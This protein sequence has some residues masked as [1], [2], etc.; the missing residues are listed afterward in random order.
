[1]K[2]VWFI[3]LILTALSSPLLR[4]EEQPPFDVSDPAISENFRRIYF[5]M[6]KHRHE[7]DDSSFLSIFKSSGSASTLDSFKIYA[8]SVTVS[9]SAATIVAP[10]GLTQMLYTMATHL[11]TSSATCSIQQWASSFTVTNTSAADDKKIHWWT[12]GK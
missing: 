5:L 2:W 12:F 8:G 10:V 7:Q 3:A 11:E 4:A 9:A 1:M 6:D